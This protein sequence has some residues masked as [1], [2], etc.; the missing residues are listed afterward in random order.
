MAKWITGDNAILVLLVFSLLVLVHSI[1]TISEEKLRQDA[2]KVL[3]EISQDVTFDEQ[4]LQE[5]DKQSYNNLKQ[6]WNLDSDFCIYIED[7]DGNPLL[8]PVGS[9]KIYVAGNPCGDGS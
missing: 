3:S 9:D 8:R 5:L 1:L 4:T 6:E 7:M 2:E